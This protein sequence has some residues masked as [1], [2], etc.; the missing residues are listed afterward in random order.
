MAFSNY[1]KLVA[2][3][4]TLTELL[5]SAELTEGIQNELQWI[6]IVNI[7]LSIITFFG[8][9]TVLLALSKVSTLHRASKLLFRTLAATDFCVG[10]ISQP[11]TV[12]SLMSQ[13]HGQF[14]VCR[15]ASR[16]R[17]L[18]SHVLCTMSLLS[19]AA[20]NVDRL[21]ALSLRLRYR[22]FVTLK[23]MYVIV[24]AFWVLSIAFSVMSLISEKTKWFFTIV[25]LSCFIISGISYAKI[26]LL[27][28]HN[29]TQ[30]NNLAV[31][32]RQPNPVRTPNAEVYKK[33]V[34]TVFWVQIGLV[35][36]YVPFMIIGLIIR[37]NQTVPIVLAWRCTGTLLFF[38]S[39][40][41]PFLYCWKMTSVKRAMKE[42]VRKIC[43]NRSSEF[44]TTSNSGIST[45]NSNSVG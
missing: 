24:T 1:S 11:L 10:V 14:N 38:N 8:N 26:F 31:C 41:N 15:Y 44:V 3:K 45:I 43:C 12:L 21:F 25:L 33:T 40:L 4:E 9:A 20:I 29:Q 39:S 19:S 42:T 6:S 34:S 32:Q 13:V 30:V 7:L 28:H 23:R 16:V 5:C 18:I 35:V 17:F 36:C 37:N 2:N 27:L 22:Q